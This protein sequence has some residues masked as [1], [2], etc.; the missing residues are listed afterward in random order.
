[1]ATATLRKPGGAAVKF[2]L[3]NGRL[4]V[5]RQGRAWVA[6]A[7]A[8]A[9]SWPAL[10]AAQAT[11]YPN[12]PIRLIV[13]L[14]PAGSTDIVARIVAQKLNEGLGQQVIVDNR[15]GAASTIGNGLV[16][17]AAPDGYTLLFASASLGTTPSL[18]R[19]LSYDPV[20]DLAPVAPIG[21]SF[22]V[23]VVHPSV[24][25]KSVQEFIAL[26]KAKPKQILYATAGTGSITHLAVELFMANAKID[27]VSVPF[28]GGAPALVAFL[29]GEAPAIFSPIA[30]IL[31]HLRTSSKVRT[32]AVTS[33]KRVPELPD[34]PT[35]SESG[36]PGATV[37]TMT[38]IYVPAGTPGGIINQLN[39]EINRMM[40][41]P[42]VRDR[43]AGNGL[44]PIGGTPEA[45]GD[46][47]KS[48]ITRWAKVIK[49][50]GIKVE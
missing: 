23:L 38:G 43:F 7:V 44:V 47:L 39:T 10:A 2:A 9:V 26:A 11:R 19:K 5:C 1:M 12:R 36:L 48:E 21:Q 14:P 28:K 29:S 8:L 15:P 22:F 25:A 33:P 40:K 35:L 45:L 6:V 49:E 18:Y 32:L 37:I 4:V 31:P 27:M 16:A 34:T 17:H 46:Y 3:E 13:P 24:P 41:Q 50:A 20:K 30:E 42:E